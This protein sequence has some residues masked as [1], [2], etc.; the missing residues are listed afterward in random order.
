MPALDG[1]RGLAILLV[2]VFH[3]RAPDL[4]KWAA[5]AAGI[6][7]CGVDLFFVLSG[8]LITGILLDTRDSARCLPVFW[9]RRVLRIFPLYFAALALLLAIAPAGWKPP[10]GDQGFYWLYLNNWVF[11]LEDRQANH[12]LGHFW[13]LA[14]EEQFYLLWPI[15]VWLLPPRWMLRAAAAGIVVSAASRIWVV[16]AGLEPEAIY[17]GALFR[18][19]ALLAGSACAALVRGEDWAWLARL[20][21]RGLLAAASA[22]ALALGLAGSTHYQNP[23]IQTIGYTIL[24]FGFACLVMQCAVSQGGWKWLQVRPLQWFGRYSYGL[25][26]WHWPIAFLLLQCGIF[27]GWSGVVG[28]QTAGFALSVA[29]A[30]TSY[31]A[32]EAPALSL[33]RHFTIQSAARAP[34]QRGFFSS[35][36]TA[37]TTSNRSPTMP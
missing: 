11:L 30:W 9:A 15:A 10:P 2:M 35:S 28:M 19:D 26:V 20:S 27:E 23:W 37:G 34:A 5:A 32:L 6:G 24:W 25:Y 1:V 12:I 14:V 8:F 4:P 7:W 36:M 21:Q 18:L 3:F 22:L 17:R 16:T 13:S 29:M 31:H 33:K